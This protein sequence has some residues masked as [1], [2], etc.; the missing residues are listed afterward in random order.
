MPNGS[1]ITLTHGDVLVYIKKSPHSLS[2]LPIGSI[3]TFAA[4]EDFDNKTLLIVETGSDSHFY[5]DDFAKVD[6]TVEGLAALVNGVRHLPGYRVICNV[7]VPEEVIT[8]TEKTVI[9]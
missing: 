6:V 5:L 1:D 4:W 7:V 8:I 2:L 3:V 9:M